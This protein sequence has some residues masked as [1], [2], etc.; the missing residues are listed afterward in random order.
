MPY[1]ELKYELINELIDI[2]E[3]S[4]DKI[5]KYLKYYDKLKIA[6]K[7]ILSN[8]DLFRKKLRSSRLIEL[9]GVDNKSQNIIMY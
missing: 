2:I 8:I 9:L 1:K 5:S 3:N 6:K 4:F 7:V